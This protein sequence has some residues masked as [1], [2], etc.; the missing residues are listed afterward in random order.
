MPPVHEKSAGMVSSRARV[1]AAPD[2]APGLNKEI[3]STRGGGLPPPASQHAQGRP[4]AVAHA[5]VAHGVTVAPDRHV[6]PLCARYSLSNAG[7]EPPAL[8]CVAGSYHDLHHC[9]H[10]PEPAGAGGLCGCM[11]GDLRTVLNY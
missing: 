5:A 9:G 7:P 1:C 6:A 11:G 2:R 4:R 8:L 10:R 3:P